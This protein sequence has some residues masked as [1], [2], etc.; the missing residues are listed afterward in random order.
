MVRLA[1]LMTLTVATTATETVP[2]CKP[3]QIQAMDYGRP[4][5]HT[6]SIDLYQKIANFSRVTTD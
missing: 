2:P 1:H 5:T 4:V 3:V 6:D